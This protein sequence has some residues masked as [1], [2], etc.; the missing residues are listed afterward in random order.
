MNYI[1]L[2]KVLDFLAFMGKWAVA[3]IVF[4]LAAALAFEAI[5]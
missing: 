3:G 2:T 1:L 4:G 5:V